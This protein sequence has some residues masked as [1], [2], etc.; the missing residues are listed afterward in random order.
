VASIEQRQLQQ[1]LT[2]LRNTVVMVCLRK[3]GYSI[4]TRHHYP[5][6]LPLKVIAQRWRAQLDARQRLSLRRDRQQRLLR[7]GVG[8]LLLLFG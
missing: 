2:A 4:N 6:N 7:Q 8:L 1:Q 3:Q 5:A